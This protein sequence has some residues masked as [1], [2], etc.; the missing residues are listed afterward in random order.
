MAF[1]LIPSTEPYSGLSEIEI[2]WRVLDFGAET[3][4][5]AQLLTARH[6]IERATAVDLVELPHRRKGPK[7]RWLSFD[8]NEGSHSRSDRSMLSC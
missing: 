4:A 5:L 1:L 2:R 7:L 8:L 6:E 3:G